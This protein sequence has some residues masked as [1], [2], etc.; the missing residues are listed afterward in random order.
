[1]LG[2]DPVAMDVKDLLAAA[3][4]GTIDAQENPLTNTFNFGLH[5]HHRYITLSGHFFGAAVLLCN[6]AQFGQ[7][8]VE[9]QGAV[10]EAAAAATAA[11]RSFA[12]NDD[13]TMLAALREA[14]NE[15]VTLS[16][17]ERAGFAAA[18]APLVA[19]QRQRFGAE[20]FQYLP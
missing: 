14:G 11:Q 10:G 2:F 20:L 9:V 17:R 6:E 12:A 16:S 7:W 3:A 13:E 18:V 5:R 8:P 4:A 15:V 1:M 19:T